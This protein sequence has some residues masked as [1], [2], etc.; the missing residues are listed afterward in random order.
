VQVASRKLRFARCH[1]PLAP[2][3]LLQH[4]DIRVVG[5][6]AAAPDLHGF[7]AALAQA[8]EADAV[9]AIELDSAQLF[10]QA[11]QLGFINFGFEDRFLHTLAKVFERAREA[12]A[13]L[14][15]GNVVGNQD[16]HR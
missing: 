12:E 9:V 13:D 16:E 1:F 7:D 6:L 8:V 5:N 3:H 14:V 4:D 11:G 2:C 15:V 10:A